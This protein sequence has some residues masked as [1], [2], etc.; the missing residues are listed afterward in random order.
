MFLEVLLIKDGGGI[1]KMHPLAYE[2]I[3]FSPVI[4]IKACLITFIYWL[5][6]LKVI[7]WKFEIGKSWFEGVVV[8]PLVLT[9]SDSFFC[10]FYDYVPSAKQCSL[11]SVWDVY[12]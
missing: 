12:I 10:L 4:L 5:L 8:P 7:F 1:F 6:F 3:P 9:I 2:S 11:R